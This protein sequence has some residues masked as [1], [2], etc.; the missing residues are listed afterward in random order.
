MPCQSFC[1]WTYS[2]FA[3]NVSF[4]EDKTGR[5]S[6][7]A[8]VHSCEAMDT[9]FKKTGY[10]YASSEMLLPEGKPGGKLCPQFQYVFP[11][12]HPLNRVAS[13]MKKH[14][15][16]VNH[17][18]EEMVGPVGY[19]LAK[20]GS[21]MR[22]TAAVSNYYIRAL[23]GD[24]VFFLPADAINDTHLQQAKDILE[25]FSAVIPLDLL[26]TTYSHDVL[27]KI[28]VFANI[29]EARQSHVHTDQNRSINGT[30]PAPLPAVA[31]NPKATW[32]ETAA[33]LGLKKETVL[34]TNRFD[35]RLYE[36]ALERFMRG[37]G[38]LD[39]EKDAKGKVHSII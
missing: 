10:Q 30:P 37:A 19:W 35:L 28:P 39:S 8:A 15:D 23:L 13:E 25:Q 4:I 6:C 2:S 12:R 33:K 17:F 38:Q 18:Y 7:K 29:T 24:S 22:T 9:W 21:A 27:R 36:W 34:W 32:Q 11:M 20:R 14:S 1:D 26:D 5:Y 16:D 3:K 31:L